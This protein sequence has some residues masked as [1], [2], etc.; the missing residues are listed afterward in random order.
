MSVNTRTP[1]TLA[2][3]IGRHWAANTAVPGGLLFVEDDAATPG[4]LYAATLPPAAHRLTPAASLTVRPS[5]ASDPATPMHAI[6]LTAEAHAETPEDA[7]A[8]LEDLCAV[9]WPNDGPFH[10]VPGGDH[11]MIGLVGLPDLGPGETADV[12][13]IVT[14]EPD[15]TPAPI[16]AGHDTRDADGQAA[17]AMTMTAMC[18]R[19]EVGS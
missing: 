2:Q 11:N 14:L 13:R 16:D 18:T 4:N 10:V 7:L 3:Q 12:W 17:A 19:V 8:M 5:P 1:R 6:T 15:S 9:L